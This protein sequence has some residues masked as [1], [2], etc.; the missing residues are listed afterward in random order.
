[1]NM[2]ETAEFVG[3]TLTLQS[4]SGEGTTVRV[5]IAST[6]KGSLP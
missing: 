4:R 5:E 3:G 1:M 6:L 2:R